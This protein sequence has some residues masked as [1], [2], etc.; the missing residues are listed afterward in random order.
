MTLKHAE[1]VRRALTLALIVTIALLNP[2]Q[3]YGQRP[4]EITF[5]EQVDRNEMT[6]AVSQELIEHSPAWTEEEGCPPLNARK[7]KKISENALELLQK[8]AWFVRLTR[9]NL[10][11]SMKWRFVR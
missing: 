7:A 11:N 6:Y 10:G 8:R 2:Q 1:C 3:L 9:I 5:V 4:D